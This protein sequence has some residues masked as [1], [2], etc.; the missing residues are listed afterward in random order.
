MRRAVAIACL[1]LAGCDVAGVATPT[2]WQ[3]PSEPPPAAAEIV[4]GADEAPAGT[5]F[6]G[7]GEDRAALTVAV[8]SGRSA[9]F[10]ALPGFVDGQYRTFSG[11]GGALLA[12]ALVFGSEEQAGDAYELFLDEFESS[13][14]YGLAGA[15][16]GLGDEGVCAT[17]SVPTPLGEE[18]I[19]VWRS[20]RV[21]LAAGGVGAE[22]VRTSAEEMDARVT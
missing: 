17:G 4:L 18:T 5:E 13:D 3:Q 20:G 9:Q 2:P 10:L 6:N 1:L 21:V 12:I 22:L 15:A 14:G 16:A 19:C 11:E 7:H 8:I